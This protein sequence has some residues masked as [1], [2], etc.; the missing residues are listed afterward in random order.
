MQFKPK[1]EKVIPG[2]NPEFTD[3]INAANVDQIKSEMALTQKGIEEARDFKKNDQNVLHLK[4]QYT[5]VVASANDT[6]KAGNNRMKF[7]VERLKEMG[8]L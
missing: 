5:D 8:A 1:K 7:M 2:L 4:Q 3:K 6:I